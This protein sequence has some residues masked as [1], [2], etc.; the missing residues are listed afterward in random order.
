MSPVARSLPEIPVAREL[1]NNIMTSASFPFVPT[2]SVLRLAHREYTAF[3]PS[4]ELRQPPLAME[5]AMA[6]YE[7]QIDREVRRE[8]ARATAKLPPLFASAGPQGGSR[9]SSSRKPRSKTDSKPA[10]ST[11]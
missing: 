11:P 3:P 5:A 10:A 7:A 2:P 1:A 4:N 8:I 6:R 9:R